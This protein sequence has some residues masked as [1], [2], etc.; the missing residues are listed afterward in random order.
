M[1][2]FLREEFGNPHSSEHIYGWNSNKAVE[3]SQRNVAELINAD[4]DELVFTS[5]ATEANNLALLGLA[6]GEN[7]RKIKRILTTPIEHKS[8]INT[9]RILRDVYGWETITIP[10]DKC[11]LLDLDYI[12][13]QLKRE[14]SILSVIAVNNEIGTIQ[15]IKDIGRLSMKY[16]SLFH[17]DA[18][19]APTAIQLDVIEQNVDLMSLSAHKMYGPKGIGGLYIRRDIQNQIEPIIYGGDQQNGLRGGTIPT[20]LCVGMGEASKIIYSKDLQVEIEAIMRMGDLFL[21]NLQDAE[22]IIKVNGPKFSNRH[23]GNLNLRFTGLPAQEIISRLQPRVAASTGSACTSGDPEPSYVLRAIGLSVDEA[24]SSIRFSFGRFTT[25][26]EIY[27]ATEI[28]KEVLSQ[29][30]G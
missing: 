14:P 12:E 16:G 18:S 5:G 28:L 10:V 20:H 17:C 22:N 6:R 11:G 8:I 7:R 3:T 24:K 27:E 25:E 4:L 1:A 13:M 29:M 15:P 9:A 2:P 23:P 30:K 21:N 26:N 19:Q